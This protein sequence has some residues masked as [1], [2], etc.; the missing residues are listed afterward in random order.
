M[1]RACH[2]QEHLRTVGIAQAEQKSKQCLQHGQEMLVVCRK[3]SSASCL[4]WW[5]AG[6]QHG[7]NDSSASAQGA[8]AVGT[9]VQPHG[10]L[11]NHRTQIFQ[12]LQCLQMLLSCF[13]CG[14]SSRMS[15]LCCPKV[16][17]RS[18][19][20]QRESFSV[21]IVVM[22]FNTCSLYVPYVLDRGGLEILRARSS[23]VS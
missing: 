2:G 19:V 11:L 22:L 5:R 1:E 4:K 23:Q 18:W 7:K 17:H 13:S 9:E 20:M 14:A 6:F 8:D 21:G 12:V 15:F 3:V 10:H 16:W